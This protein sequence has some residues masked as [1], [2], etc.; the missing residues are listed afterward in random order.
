MASLAGAST[1][2]LDAVTEL[3][4]AGKKVPNA[5]RDEVEKLGFTNAVKTIDAHNAGEVVGVEQATVKAEKE[6]PAKKVEDKKTAGVDKKKEGVD[7]EK[8]AYWKNLIPSTKTSKPGVAAEAYNKNSS[9]KELRTG[10]I[11]KTPADKTPQTKSKNAALDAVIGDISK[12]DFPETTPPKTE[13][14]KLSNLKEQVAAATKTPPTETSVKNTSPTADLDAKIEDI[15][16]QL[17]D[18]P[19]DKSLLKQLKEARAQRDKVSATA[20]QSTSPTVSTSAATPTSTP[21]S[22]PVPK[23]I[24]ELTSKAGSPTDSVELENGR[25]L[26]RA[27]FTGMGGTS[28]EF[29]KMV[30]GRRSYGQVQVE[31]AWNVKNIKEV[32]TKITEVDK[33]I[34]E[35]KAKAE[36][37][38][39][40]KPEFR[41]AETDLKREKAQ[42]D[43][44]LAELEQQKADLSAQK[45][46]VASK[47]SP[48]ALSKLQQTAKQNSDFIGP[49][50][51]GEEATSSPLPPGPV[52]KE[53]LVKGA[54]GNFKRADTDYATFN[55]Q[56]GFETKLNEGLYNVKFIKESGE[57]LPPEQVVELKK[58]IVAAQKEG[59]AGIAK[60]AK[61]L[62]AGGILLGVGG[63]FLKPTEEAVQKVEPQKVT[64]PTPAP[65]EPTEPTVP[66]APKAPT[67]LGKPAAP[68]ATTTKQVG[69]K[70]DKPE[71][72]GIFWTNIQ[73]AVAPMTELDQ[74]TQERFKGQ[75]DALTTAIKDATAS[76]NESIKTAKD[77]AARR[78]RI[79]SWGQIFESLG[80]AAIKYFAAR[81]G[82]RLGQRIGSNLQLEKY[83]WSSDLNRSMKKL[84]IDMAE[85]KEKFGIAKEE[86]EA[87]RKALSKEREGLQERAYKRADMFLKA[88]LDE[89]ERA[90]TEAA[91]AKMNAEERAFKQQQNAAEMANALALKKLDIDARVALALNKSDQKQKVEINNIKSTYEN[92]GTGFDEIYE[93]PSKKKEA[94]FTKFKATT[95]SLGLTDAELIELNKLTSP[96]SES[97]SRKEN[98][99]AARAILQQAYER[100]IS[101]Y[102]G[103]AGAPAEAEQIVDMVSPKGDALRV[104]ASK[105]KELEAQGARLGKKQ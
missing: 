92:A 53:T 60:Y 59:S 77:E 97:W 12:R 68:A 71:D 81:E 85:A 29:D 102:A 50:K 82:K 14:E 57:A 89:R 94:L 76:Y 26:T 10:E 20:P 84:E 18:N 99:I 28:E 21:A 13:S 72:L 6:V 46:E 98:A 19:D 70:V 83:D 2:V 64:P 103:G 56:T 65:T 39:K 101:G 48:E 1:K 93:A 23:K 24:K 62:A 25:K 61:G 88:S 3:I 96:F 90:Q 91:R 52:Y 54:A 16:N 80:Q 49:P 79:A 37:L 8:V 73:K 34:A 35:R 30:Q 11:T 5:M 41:Q 38:S 4:K 31:D 58:G 45:E 33:Q 15:S 78:E 22:T 43:T 66:P 32:D 7:E 42:N 74:A 67:V 36:R 104:P 47:T 87:G 40:K 27:E 95:K 69:I 55:K 75:E 86:V 17:A 105:V 100:K 63:Q 9:M 51:A 44:A